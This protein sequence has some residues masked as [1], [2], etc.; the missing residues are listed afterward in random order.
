LPLDKK[1][2]K[3]F[4]VL[5]KGKGKYIPGQIKNEAVL[6]LGARSGKSFLSSICALYEATRGEYQK[7]V[8]K[9][10]YIY[11]A[12]IATR[13]KQAI[14]IIQTNCL[15]MLENS[16]VLKKMISKTTELEITLK[17]NIKIVSG[18]CNSTALRGLAI[19]VLILDEISFYRIE[20]PKADETIFNSLRP[21]QAQFPNNK[22]FLIST[23]GAKQGL[24]FNYFEQGFSV[25]DR[26]TCQ[27]STD[28]V[29]PVIP[30]AFL[31]KEKKRDIDNYMRE[32]EAI[33]AEKVEAFLTLELIR[34]ALKFAGDLKPRGKGKY[35]AGIDQSGLSGRDRFSFAISHR[36]GEKI[37][38]DAVRSWNTKDFKVILEEISKLKDI[39]NLK[40]VLIDQYA[41]AYVSIALKEIGLI[42]EKRPSLAEVFTNLKSLALMDCLF[43]PASP[44]IE[45]SLQ[46]TIAF[47]GKSNRLTIAHERS[48]TYGHGDIADAISSAVFASS[49]E[50]A[51]RR[52]GSVYHGGMG[53]KIINTEPPKKEKKKF[54]ILSKRTGGVYFEN[55]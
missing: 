34:S 10:E 36:E 54:K 22:L 29:N 16:P 46:N 47:Y 6:A 37:Y 17:N 28:Y 50:K 19:A 41:Q 45:Q 48:V 33:F 51:V 5:T 9:G 27:A 32:F 35:K 39:Y 25:P 3:I 15:R 18:P 20:G 4:K 14:A 23:A 42:A 44:E 53:K 24:F 11:I 31:E 52:S 43:L 55:I 1:Q 26:L 49:K 7:Y 21:R 38:V 13:E 12:I 2:L 30:I 40:D 8:S